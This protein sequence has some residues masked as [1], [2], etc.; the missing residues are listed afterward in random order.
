MTHVLPFLIPV[1]MFATAAVL[2]VGLF[3]M[4]RGGTFNKQYGNKL[5]QMR[6]LLQ[7]VAIGLIVL[8]LVISG[9]H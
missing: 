3:A 7:A 1:A 5:M 4:F 8:F 2:A 9:K 6:V